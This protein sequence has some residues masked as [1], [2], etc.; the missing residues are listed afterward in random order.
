M[1][2]RETVTTPDP[3]EHSFVTMDE[4]TG[5]ARSLA[6]MARKPSGAPD[7]VVGIA[8][9]GTLPA[10]LVAEA[11]ALP[12]QI[13]LVQH[14]GSAIKRRLRPIVDFLHIPPTWILNPWVRPFWA[15]FQRRTSALVENTASFAFGV[16]GKDVL[17]VDDCIETGKTVKYIKDRL[18][19]AGAARV[20]VAVIS[21]VGQDRPDRVVEPEF[22][23]TH[24]F[25]FYPWSNN[26]PHHPAF[27][28]FMTARDIQIY[29]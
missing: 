23:L 27:D 24:I 28:A 26:S 22:F 8:N 29:R 1:L 11:L 5:M 7:M 4:V 16:D 13:V 15:L 17:L 6:A 12:L 19:A 21:C 20:A 2:D 9:G 3:I 18:L 25:Q 10:Y 14:K